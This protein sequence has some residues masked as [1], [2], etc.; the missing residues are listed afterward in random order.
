MLVPVTLEITKALISGN[1]EGIEKLGIKT[2]KK[3]PTEDTIDILPIIN[4]S[5]EKDKLPSGFEFWMI[6]IKD[7]MLVIGDIGFHGKPDEKGEVEIGY[8]L[9]EHERGKGFGFEALNA[10]MDWLSFQ[11]TVNVIKAECLIDNKPSTRILQKVGM[12]E[13]NRDHS[14]I[15]WEFVKTVL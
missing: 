14:L 15:Y 9:V 1:N 8:G 4:N 6:I 7:T 3:W 13:V 11:E 2:D 10:I 12:K 5:L